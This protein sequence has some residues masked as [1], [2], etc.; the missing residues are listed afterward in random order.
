MYFLLKQRLEAKYK[1]PFPMTLLALLFKD[2]S[3]CVGRHCSNVK[4]KY[5]MTAHF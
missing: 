2:I 1:A 4:W 3:Y 5:N